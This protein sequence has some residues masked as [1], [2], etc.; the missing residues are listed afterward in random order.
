MPLQGCAW[1]RPA[2]A[3]LFE[4]LVWQGPES[5]GAPFANILVDFFESKCKND[6]RDGPALSVGPHITAAA[7]QQHTDSEAKESR[8]GPW[9]Q[10]HHSIHI[11]GNESCLETDAGAAS[12]SH[13]SLHSTP[14]LTAAQLI[15][16]FPP[17]HRPP[18]AVSTA[19]VEARNCD[20]R[21]TAFCSANPPTIGLKAYVS[22]IGRYFGCSTVCLMYACAYILRL[23]ACGVS[24]THLTV[25]RLLGTAVVVAVK[26]AEDLQWT[27]AHYARVTGI[28]LAELNSMEFLMCSLLDFALWLH[29]PLDVLSE[30]RQARKVP[31]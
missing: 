23:E 20:A 24:L 7:A 30:V 13:A 11:T 22:R 10:Y 3:A 17:D 8:A 9:R 25:H 5:W 16:E 26:H 4:P 6:S 2:I 1:S 21:Q 28:S 27:N 29:G 18:P 14:Q 19:C 15:P 31:D 12:P